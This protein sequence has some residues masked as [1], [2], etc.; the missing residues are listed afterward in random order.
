MKK[1]GL[2]SLFLL[3]FACGGEDAPENIQLDGPAVQVTTQKVVSAISEGSRSFVLNGRVAAKNAAM[4]S[5][6]VM[7]NISQ[8]LV[9]EGQM[10]RKGQVL[11]TVNS[12]DLK[13]QQSRIQAQ[14]SEAEAGLKNAKR[15]HERFKNLYESKSITQ[16]EFND[17]EMQLE[18]ANARVTAAKEALKELNVQLGYANVVAPFSGRVAKKMAQIGSMAN[19]GMPLFSIESSGELIIEVDVPA[20]EI[21]HLQLKDEVDIT[22][23]DLD[24]SMKGKTSLINPSASLNGYQYRVE[25]SPSSSASIKDVPTGM[26]AKVAF[27]IQ[28]G[29][30]TSEKPAIWIPKSALV[31]QGQLQGVYTISDQQTALLRWLQ[32]GEEKADKVEVVSGLESEATL[33]ISAQGR[34]YNGVK[35]TQ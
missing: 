12:T 18:M 22:L 35:I 3:L 32:L 26:N 25:I 31:Q 1:I 10:V 8:V 23:Q 34:L 2:Y 24:K 9:K 6:R 5:T 27:S 33:I 15:N 30:K 7:G 16:K 28:S 11:A 29:E 21:K 20:S 14:I 19:P 4:V 13:A 17:V